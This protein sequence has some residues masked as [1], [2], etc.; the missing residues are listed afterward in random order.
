MPTCYGACV[1]VFVGGPVLGGLLSG[2]GFAVLGG[3]VAISDREGGL[4]I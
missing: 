1:L 4:P 2:A 3:W